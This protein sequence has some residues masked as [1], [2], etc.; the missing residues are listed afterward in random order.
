MAV[1]EIDHVRGYI[2]R[3]QNGPFIF[4]FKN[5][6]FGAEDPHVTSNRCQK[7]EMVCFD[8]Q[9]RKW[10]FWRQSGPFLN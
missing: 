9:K 4:K 8:V 5:G 6:P 1:I 2:H 10:A 7:A 3:C